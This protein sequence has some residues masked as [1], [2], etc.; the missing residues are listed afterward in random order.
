[1]LT[2][3]NFK[4]FFKSKTDKVLAV[5]IPQLT[6]DNQ[7]TV[8]LLGESGS[9]KSLTSLAI[10]GLL[11][12]N[13]FI[14]KDTQIIFK[15]QDISNFS[16]K[17]LQ[18]FRGKKIA[19]IFQ[20][21]M[22]A[23]NPVLTVGQQIG[24]ILL[25]HKLC[26]KKQLSHKIIKLL[27]QV[28]LP[29]P[30]QLIKQYPH[31]LSGGMKQRVMIAMA[32]ACEPDLLIADEP[33]SA[34]D[35][36]VQ[37]EIIQLLKKIQNLRNLS[38]LFI[39]HD[40]EMARNIADKLLVFYSGALMEAGETK[41]VFNQ[42][43]HPYTKGLLGCLPS[44]SDRGRKLNTIQGQVLSLA[45]AHEGCQFYSRCDFRQAECQKP[46]PLITVSP[47]HQVACILPENSLQEKV[48]PRV[49]PVN[50]DHLN[51]SIIKVENLSIHFDT[52]NGL[53]RKR[54]TFKAVDA[55]SFEIEKGKTTAIVGESGS[56]KTT[57]AKAILGV[58]PL[59]CGTV[60]LNGSSIHQFKKRQ[61]QKHIQM[62]FQDP[63]SSLNP[64]MLVG[65]IIAEGMQALDIGLKKHRVEK[66]KALLHQTGLPQDSLGRY[67]HEFS[68]GQRQRICIARALAVEPE[69]LICDE[70]TS[71]LDVSVQ[72]QIINLLKD[73]QTEHGLTY[74][75]IT[76]NMALTAYFADRILVM[77]AGKRVEMAKTPDLLHNPQAVYTQ[78]LINSVKNPNKNF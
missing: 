53:F 34:L 26:T 73:L 2:L 51:E 42:P 43:L 11:P 33:T 40:I 75:F 14:S 39:T 69:I 35:V 3:K 30:T 49:S 67:P 4:I 25:H 72:A 60:T 45:N 19:M 1:M 28:E 68:G 52:K 36:A 58:Q 18:Q 47:Q 57:L 10:M 59:T 61:W 46:V 37:Q 31:E 41:A 12:N 16:E 21:P 38:I 77:K 24:E 76:H 48:K 29:R 7:Q 8:A 71:A 78:K 22:T 62:I 65:D 74:L 15:D 55:M 6:I 20:E 70:P 50:H 63:F 9:G 44:F 64:R 66:I 13:A 17:K 56:G 27:E 23:L 5:N 54:Q 32:I